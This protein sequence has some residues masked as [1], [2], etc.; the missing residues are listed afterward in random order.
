MNY[1]YKNMTWDR[2]Y[3]VTASQIFEVLSAT[4][5]M[6]LKKK[7][8]DDV[9][10]NFIKTQPTYNSLLG[11]YLEKT[12]S[13]EIYKAFQESQSTVFTARGE[14]LE[15]EIFLRFKKAVPLYSEMDFT[16]QLW[17]MKNVKG[18]SLGA[19]LDYMCCKNGAVVECKTTLLSQWN[20]YGNKPSFAW[21]LQLQ[22]QM[23]LVKS[24]VGFLAIGV[25]DNNSFTDYALKIREFQP[26]KKMQEI[27]EIACEEFFE[28]ITK[29]MKPAGSGIK[30]EK[31]LINFINEYEKKI[32]K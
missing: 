12:I 7:V 3:S 2:K 25:G 9:Q 16:S 28:I 18:G 4:S 21:T 30:K 17:S 27:I 1:N 24:S 6:L 11:L 8:I 31:D 20:K 14:R 22:M 15:E 23:L 19:Y 32:S 10:F 13:T 29:E 5:E 26:N